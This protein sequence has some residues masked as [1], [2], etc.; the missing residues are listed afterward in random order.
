MWKSCSQ[1]HRRRDLKKAESGSLLDRSLPPFVPTPLG[2]PSTS[3]RFLFPSLGGDPALCRERIDPNVCESD[4]GRQIA[5]LVN[6]K[7]LHPSGRRILF[8]QARNG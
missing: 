2:S 5:M 4:R 1:L 7:H 8:T 3:F 6:G